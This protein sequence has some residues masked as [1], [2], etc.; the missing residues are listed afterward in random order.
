MIFTAKFRKCVEITVWIPERSNYN[1]EKHFDVTGC[2]FRGGLWFLSKEK[3]EKRS[4]NKKKYSLRQL[5]QD[6]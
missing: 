2:L 1:A 6:Q 5:I 4:R 3:K